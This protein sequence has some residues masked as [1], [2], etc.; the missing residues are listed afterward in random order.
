MRH[1]HDGCAH[2]ASPLFTA[3]CKGVVEHTGIP[4]RC[5]KLNGLQHRHLTAIV[6][7]H[8]EVHPAPPA[9]PAGREPWESVQGK[10]V[11]HHLSSSVCLDMLSRL[12]GQQHQLIKPVDPV[13]QG[14]DSSVQPCFHGIDLVIR[15]KEPCHPDG[16]QG[17]DE[18][19]DLVIGLLLPGR[20]RR[21]RGG[22]RSRVPMG[23][24]GNPLTGSGMG[25]EGGM[26]SAEAEGQEFTPPAIPIQWIKKFQEI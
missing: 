25:F 16:H 21:S 3:S 22:S 20:S 11:E 15:S 26:G 10:G 12:E 5:Q 24:L 19:D 17:N 7:A 8:Q 1:I 13:V 23:R 6:L 9:Q 14:I 18:P 2:P 4:L